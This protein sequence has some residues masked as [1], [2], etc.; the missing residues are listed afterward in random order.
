LVCLFVHKHNTNNTP[1]TH[2]TKQTT[3][4]PPPPPP[5][6]NPKKTKQSYAGIGGITELLG[7]TPVQRDQ[8]PGASVLGL[9]PVVA[10]LV[11]TLLIADAAV[12]GVLR[13]CAAMGTPTPFDSLLQ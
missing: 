1:T 6:K 10:K 3:P 5:P 11:L 4:P 13:L 7:M 9:N 2:T 12:F 8:N